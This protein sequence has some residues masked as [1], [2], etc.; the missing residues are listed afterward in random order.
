MLIEK[1][2]FLLVLEILMSDLK[3]HSEGPVSHTN[4]TEVRSASSNGSDLSFIKLLAASASAG[5]ALLPTVTSGRP[6]QSFNQ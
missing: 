5:E 1:K 4:L 3:S 6:L 2:T